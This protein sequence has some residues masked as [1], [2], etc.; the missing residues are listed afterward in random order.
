VTTSLDTTRSVPPCVSFFQGASSMKMSTNMAFLDLRPIGM[1]DSP[2]QSHAL[3]AEAFEN[4][5]RA[6]RIA[7]QRQE[8]GNTTAAIE[9]TEWAERYARCAREFA[10]NARM[11]TDQQPYG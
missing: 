4:A 5:A 9:L 6:H 2:D 7:A 8:Q 10:L 3:A 1:P 11:L